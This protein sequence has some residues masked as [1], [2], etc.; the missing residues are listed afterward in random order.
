M[1]V[2]VPPEGGEASQSDHDSPGEP[3]VA[4]ISSRTALVAGLPAD[5]RYFALSV[6]ACEALLGSGFFWAADKAVQIILSVIMCVIL[7]VGMFFVYLI[8]MKNLNYAHDNAIRIPV[9][10]EKDENGRTQRLDYDI[11]IATAM[12]AVHEDSALEEKI[13]HIDA[14]VR[15]LRS[16]TSKDLRI[17]YATAQVRSRADFEDPAVALKNIV[18]RMRASKYLALIYAE[19]VPTSA[20]IEVGM[21][22]SLDKPS[23]WFLK[24]GVQVPYLMKGAFSN[25]VKELPTVR[26]VEFT[27][28]D[29]LSRKIKAAAKEYFSAAL[30]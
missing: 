27:D 13:D 22:L 3:R 26:V 5:V 10:T 6:F 28:F 14:I 2:E 1:T 15:E 9:V 30:E 17:F 18:L 20:L 25:L 21:A 11:F 8:V 29:D 19:Y 23:V 4:S 16:A 7:L 12:A 24:Q